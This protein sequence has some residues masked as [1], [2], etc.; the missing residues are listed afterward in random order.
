M[1]RAQVLRPVH[2]PPIGLPGSHDCLDFNPLR[3]TCIFGPET[4]T[5]LPSAWTGGL[6]SPRA[7]GGLPRGAEC[8]DLYLR[9]LSK[10]CL[11]GTILE[12]EHKD[13]VIF[14]FGTQTPK[15]THQPP[16]CRIADSNVSDR[17]SARKRHREYA[18]HEITLGGR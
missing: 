13:H 5:T 9:E 6:P 16:E 8:S 12:I 14:R 15:S 11:G 18:L 2:P 1:D 4:P 7:T 10:M 17:R 3:R